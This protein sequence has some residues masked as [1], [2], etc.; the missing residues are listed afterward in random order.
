M[1]KTITALSLIAAISGTSN[2]QSYISS[3]GDVDDSKI[4]GL[5]DGSVTDLL[6]SSSD[7]TSAVGTL[8]F[9][10][11]TFILPTDYT[12]DSGHL[13][14]AGSTYTSF[15]LI[16]YNGGSSRTDIGTFTFDQTL[17]AFDNQSSTMNGAG[18]DIWEVS[19][20][21]YPSS[22]LTGYETV[23]N[24]STGGSTANFKVTFSSP[25]DRARI[26]VGTDFSVPE[27]S[28][29]FFSALAGLALVARRKRN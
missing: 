15:Y 28:T 20:V 16:S 4:G 18:S 29:T 27:P 10:E 19:G 17:G 9:Q 24:I 7:G 12:T 2:A 11:N 25:G 23:D 3:T 6:T 26:F 14:T 8:I 5:L 21:A 13:L 1:K 22:G